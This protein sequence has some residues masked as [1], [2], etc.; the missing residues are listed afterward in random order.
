MSLTLT[1][2]LTA[3]VVGGAF[4]AVVGSGGQRHSG[5]LAGFATS[6]PHRT[7]KLVLSDAEWKKR[8]TEKQYNILRSHGTEGA[9]CGAFYDNHKTGVYRCAGCGLALFASNTKF[10]SG[11]GWPSFFQPVNKQNVWIKSDTS[12]GMVRDE[13]LCSRCDG[14]LGHVFDDAPQTATGLRFCMNSDAMTFQEGDPDK[15]LKNGH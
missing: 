5:P 7:D 15:L 8:L 10:D 9:F 12:Y 14:H 2:A 1:L 11:T 4:F 13:V 3:V 6:S